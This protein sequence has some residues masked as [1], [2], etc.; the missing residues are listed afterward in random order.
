MM[1]RKL[2]K[3]DAPQVAR[4]IHQLTKNVVEPDHL[5]K[6]I[7]V[8]PAQKNSRFLVVCRGNRVVGFGGLVWYAIPSKGLIAWVEEL[9]VDERFRRQGIGRALMEQF[10]KIALAKK[11]QQVKLTSTPAAKGLYEKLGFIKKEQDYL[12]KNL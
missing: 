7:A 11:I 10:L 3:K 6:R 9:V 2:Q 4:L 12:Y 8:L 5:E 1:I